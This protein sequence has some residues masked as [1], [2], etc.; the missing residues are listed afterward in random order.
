MKMSLIVFLSAFA[1]AVFAA[2]ETRVPLQRPPIE[3]DARTL[4]A[5]DRTS[6]YVTRSR[7]PDGASRVHFNESF[8]YVTVARVGADGKIEILCTSSEEEAQRFLSFEKP[9]SLNSA[10]PDE[11]DLK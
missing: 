8:Q 1:G 2:D 4:K 10:P 11:V 6:Q 7:A 3:F 5:F 9:V